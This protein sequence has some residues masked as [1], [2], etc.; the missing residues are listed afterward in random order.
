MEAVSDLVFDG[1]RAIQTVVDDMNAGESELRANLVRNA[2]ENGHF[3]KSAL[4]VLDDRVADGLVGRDGV[5]R[6]EFCSLCFRQAVVS[7][8]DHAAIRQGGIVREIMLE[9]SGSD[10]IALDKREIRLLDCPGGELTAQGVE[11]GL[12]PGDNYESRR[13]GIYAVQS[14]SHQRLVADGYAFRETRNYA[15]HQ[16]ARLAAHQRMDGDA[17]RFV[18]RQEVGVFVNRRDG[19][20][21]VRRDFVVGDF[22]KTDDFNLLAAAQF[23][24]LGD[25]ASVDLDI[26]GT[27]GI[28]D[29]T[30]RRR[31]ESGDKGGIQ[32][33]TALR[34]RH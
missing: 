1:E 22:G 24:A 13:S 15:I 32:T 7:A 2:G 5:E 9:R 8:I 11:G 27:Y 30:A 12:I 34:Y 10:D 31:G 19:D 28:L 25:N 33:D 4:F 17:A 26:A 23:H 14:A 6:T 21:R 20:L 3:E 18:E 29:K 16:R